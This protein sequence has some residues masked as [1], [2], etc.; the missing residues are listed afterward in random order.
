MAAISPRSN[1]K[2]IS[3]STKKRQ[4]RVFGDHH[5]VSGMPD[6]VV[7]SGN[8]LDIALW[9]KKPKWSRFSQGQILK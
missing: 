2:L 6:I 5:G 1:S 9:V 3:F 4:I 8:V 7:L